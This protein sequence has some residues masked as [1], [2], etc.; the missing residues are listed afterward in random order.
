[1]RRLLLLPLLLLAGATFAGDPPI[2]TADKVEWVENPKLPSIRAREE[3]A[4]FHYEN[5]T[6]PFP[7]NVWGG[8]APIVAA[9][10]GFEANDFSLFAQ[11]HGF[12]LDIQVIEDPSDA[13][14]A[15]AN[16]KTPILWGTV[17]MMALF[18]SELLLGPRPKVFLQLDWS[19]GGDGIVVRQERVKTANDLRGKTVVLCPFSPSHYYLLTVLRAAGIDPKDVKLRYTK[20]AYQ[21]AKAFL[22]DK[23]ID[24]VVTF[25]PDIYKLTEKF[26]QEMKLLSSTGDAKRLLADVFAVR[27]DFAKAHPEVVEGLVAGILEGLAFTQ[28]NPDAVAGQL[29]EGFKKYGIASV[30]DTKAMMH[31]AHLTNYAE[32]LAFFTDP[33]NPTSFTRT[34]D[35]AV[36]LY[37]SFGALKEALPANVIAD[38]APLKDARLAETWKASKDDY[39]A[40]PVISDAARKKLAEKKQKGSVV[41][42]VVYFDAAKETYDESSDEVAK[43]LEEVAKLAG[44][45]SGAGVLI[46]GYTDPVGAGLTALEKRRGENRQVPK[47]IAARE[48]RLVEFSSHRAEFVGKALAER[49][50]L[51]RD[52]FA[53]FGRGGEKPITTEE[54]ERWKNRRVEVT[55]IPVEAE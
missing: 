38:P 35:D 55:I 36:T 31:D 20:T 45:F 39:S 33:R 40:P 41:T 46:E 4:E 27:E 1:M 51:S 19:N 32:N 11:N 22:D 53:V 6:I 3:N 44:R 50:A 54:S 10:G 18:S 23:T 14:T 17:D 15:F 24:A 9:N 25:S 42:M 34:Y 21:A 26:P 28:K 37:R 52:Q 12:K 13:L 48:K 43:A 2:T 7:I 49:Y 30:E 16:G 47:V 29:F 8:W 5:K